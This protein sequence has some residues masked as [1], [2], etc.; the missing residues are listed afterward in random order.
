MQQL[1]GGDCD[2]WLSMTLTMKERRS[3]ACRGESASPARVAV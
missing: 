3:S 1:S 2:K